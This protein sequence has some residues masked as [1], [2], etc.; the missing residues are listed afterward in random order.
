MSEDKPRILIVDD[1]RFDIA[2][3]LEALEGICKPIVAKTGEQALRLAA[4]EPPPNLILLDVTMPDISGYEVC[5]RLKDNPRTAGIPILFVTGLQEESAI[6]QGI[7]SG[8]LDVIAKPLNPRLLRARIFNLLQLLRSQFDLLHAYTTTPQEKWIEQLDHMDDDLD[9]LRGK[10]TILIVDDEPFLQTILD[11]ALHDEFTIVTASSGEEALD[12]VHQEPRPELILLDVVMPGMDGYTVCR[13][14]KANPHT[15]DISIIFVTVMGHDTNEYKGLQMGAIDYLVKPINPVIVKTR[16]RNH[17]R[18]RQAIG[19]LRWRSRQLEIAN[20]DLRRAFGNVKELSEH[21][22]FFLGTAAHDLRSPLTSIH[23]FAQTLRDS[24]ERGD[25][26]LP[27]ERLD[28]A[29][30]LEKVSEHMLDVV[31]NLLTTDS[32]DSGLLELDRVEADLTVL[33]Q[34]VIDINQKRAREKELQLLY[35]P[36]RPAEAWVDST[37][38]REVVDNLI[39]NAIKFSPPGT[40]IRVKVWQE[41]SDAR[42]EIRDEGPGLTADD[43]ARLFGRFTRLSAKPTGG[44]KSTGLGLYL[45]RRLVDLHG[46]KILVESAPGEGATFTVVLPR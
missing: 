15:Q 37:R 6:L 36:H 22:R 40:C 41:A 29:R 13:K 35:E 16:V 24:E 25:P 1:E 20:N 14:L 27:A 31:D 8:A 26:L 11:E 7:R 32:V 9:H 30:H 33:V 3:I 34:P 4:S 28:M 5:R 2:L 17:L 10:P 23:S 39:G 42:I 44:E 18:L 12:R 21:Q 19:D 43:R 45:S 46:G 38:I